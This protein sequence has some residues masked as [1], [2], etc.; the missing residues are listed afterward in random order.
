M[1]GN[2]GGLD[3]KL[4]EQPTQIERNE[5]KAQK[6][7]GWSSNYYQ[8]PESAKEIQD[9]IEHRDMNFSV[10]NIFKAAYRLGQKTG[11]TEEYDLEK[12]IWFAKREIERLKG[13]L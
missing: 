13:C 4:P 8:I 6:L 7:T 10:G 9:L 11:T 3:W 2:K 5:A 12:I 1:G